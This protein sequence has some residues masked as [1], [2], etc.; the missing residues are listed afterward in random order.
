MPLV[1]GHPAL[2]F[3]NTLGG[4][5]ERPI[6]NLRGYGDLLGWAA[7]SG[8]TGRDSA[9][10]LTRLAERYPDDAAAALTD[11]LA[12][13]AYLDAA[14]RAHLAGREAAADLA[15]VVTAYRSALRQARLAATGDTYI[16]TWPDHLEVITWRMTTHAVDL[17]Q[18]IPLDRLHICA[19]CRYVF[20]DRSKNRSRRWC[21]MRGCGDA[22]KM[23]R[24]RARRLA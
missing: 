19:G 7:H 15:G 6:E 24:Y 17:L 12:L 2:D 11:A 18:Q 8:I 13:R 4:T 16:W 20:L 22:A 14:L 9:A 3:V 21:R 5:V 1:G 23:R 10:Q